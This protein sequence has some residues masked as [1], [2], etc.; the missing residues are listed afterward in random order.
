[1]PTKIYPDVA[2]P[3]GLNIPSLNW[4][5]RCPLVVDET[6]FPIPFTRWRRFLRFWKQMW[7]RMTLEDK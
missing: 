7:K 2:G 4:K 6:V 1:M 3:S 5:P